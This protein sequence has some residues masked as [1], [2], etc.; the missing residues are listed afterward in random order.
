MNASAI[1]AW[2]DR[3]GRRIQFQAIP[4]SRRPKN[5]VLLEYVGSDTP[6][7]KVVG[8]C[9]LAQCALKAALRSSRLQNKAS[10][11]KGND[12]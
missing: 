8:G 2:L 1:L 5:R 10:H 7:V 12:R 3:F 9:S 4:P 6:E 11:M